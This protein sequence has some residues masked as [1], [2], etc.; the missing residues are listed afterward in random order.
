M[1][2]R[3][4]P[5]DASCRRS[6][7]PTDPSGSLPAESAAFDHGAISRFNAWFFTAFAGY[8]NH[9][10][11]GH[12]RSA[13]D[14]L[15]P[16][17]GPRDRCRHRRQHG[18]P[19]AGHAPHRPRAEP[20][21]A[22]PPPRSAARPRGIDVTD[23]ATGAE[24]IPLPDA[25]VD[26]VIC[27]LVLCTVH[28]PAQA[29]GRCAA[30]CDP[31]GASGSS[32]TWPRHG[33]ACAERSS[34]PSAARGAGSSRDAVP[35]ATPRSL[36]ERRRLSEAAARTRQ[37]PP[38]A[39]LPGQ[40]RGV[41]GGDQVTPALRPSA[42]RSPTHADQH[43]GPTSPTAGRRRSGRR[44][45][46]LQGVRC[47]A[48]RPSCCSRRGRS[49]TAGCGRPTSPTSHATSPWS[50]TTPEATAAP[51]RPTD[52]PDQTTSKLVGDAVAV[53]DEVGVDRAVLVGNS[54]GTVLAY[55]LAALHPERVAGAV[56]IGTTL[57]LDG[58]TDDP[59]SRAIQTFTTSRGATRA[60]PS[61]TGTTGTGTSRRSSGS[62]WG[63][64]SPSPTPPSTSTTASPGA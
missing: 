5:E 11:R 61:T 26:E 43:E 29:L 20:G 50:P 19:G 3:P 51:D 6:T 10:A 13:F 28:D 59:L 55:L 8:I 30:C 45:D 27:S 49:P 33:P 15:A 38:L 44:R 60:G 31:A 2:T 34:G 63:R 32:S 9:I 62:S 64:P 39:V 47:T 36:I 12:K 46:R 35:T 4:E 56:M 53:L 18:P 42:G 25:S 48:G 24:A 54:F 40:H 58:R 52:P 22:R 17:H 21:D 16:G 1:Q 57:N 41:G 7:R 14:G 37:V 23:P